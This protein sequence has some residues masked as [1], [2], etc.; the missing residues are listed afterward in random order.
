MERTIRIGPNEPGSLEPPTERY[1][2]D[3]HELQEQTSGLE[4]HRAG[5]TAS[6]CLG[7]LVPALVVCL[8]AYTAAHA[9]V[10]VHVLAVD[11]ALA[12]DRPHITVLVQVHAFCERRPASSQS[13][14]Q[15]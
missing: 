13:E 3:R 2:E 5:P 15:G 7:A 12:V 4:S 9:A 11:I 8:A 14:H 6:G 10:L 1:C